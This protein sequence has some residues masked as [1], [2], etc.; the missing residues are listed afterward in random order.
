MPFPNERIYNFDA[1]MELADG[2]APVTASS[3]GQVAGSNAVIDLAGNQLSDP[4]QMARVDAV[5]V[6]D[7]NAAVIE[8]DC[9]YRFLLA[10][11]ND[12]AFG[13]NSVV[14]LGGVD[15][16]AGAM[17]S[18]GQQPGQP[19]TRQFPPRSGYVAADSTT[20]GR[21][22]LLFT[23]QLLRHKFE[24]DHRLGIYQYVALYLLMK[25]A[26]ASIT[27]QAFVS[28]LPEG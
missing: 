8:P 21:I 17:L 1:S 18:A 24:N 20:P 5:C 28:V 22:E 15:I 6:I 13:P 3:F 2:M 12:P 25:G 19:A 4:L 14:N 23:N 10:G 27:Y 11:S 16:G 7:V 26:K 9:L